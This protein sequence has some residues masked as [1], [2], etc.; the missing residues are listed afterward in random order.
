MVHENF[1]MIAIFLNLLRRALCPIMWSIFENVPCAFERKVY[2]ASLGWKA[3]SLYIYISVKSIS[4][5][6]LFSAKIF[7]LIFFWKI[8][9]SLTVGC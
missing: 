3:L 8:C 7:L 2:F 1:D 9:P 5:R 6:A 4:S